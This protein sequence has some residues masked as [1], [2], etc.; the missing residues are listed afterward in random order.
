[1]KSVREMDAI[2]NSSC[3]SSKMQ[4]IK[5]NGFNPIKFKNDS[6]AV[7]LSESLQFLRKYAVCSISYNQIKY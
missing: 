2:Q 6:H 3:E 7:Q 4:V 1:M 5:S